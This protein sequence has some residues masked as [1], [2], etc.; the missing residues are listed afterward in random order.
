M[1]SMTRDESRDTGMAMVLLLLLVYL[2]LD[3]AWL[4]TGA[5][6]AL[7]LTMSTP[8]VFGPVAV[9]W[10]GFSHLLGSV[11]SRVMLSIIF[12]LVVTP[13]GVVRRWVGKDSLQLRRFKDGGQSVFVTRNHVFA[14]ADLDRPY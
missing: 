8:R 2:A 5:V 6:V 4:V 14:P 12:A 1:R 3:H 10:L 13:I 11:M 7:V 9:V